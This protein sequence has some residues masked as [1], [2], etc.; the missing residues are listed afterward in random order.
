[1]GEAAEAQPAVLVRGLDWT[2]AAAPA[3]SL[4]RAQ[5]EDMFR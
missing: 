5:H 4:V 3:T 2:Q 1:M